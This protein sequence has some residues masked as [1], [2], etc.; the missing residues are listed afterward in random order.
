MGTGKGKTVLELINTFQEVNK[1]KIPY[2]FIDKRKG[3]VQD[4]VA[5]NEL[6][7]SL[8]NWIPE[9]DIFDM[10]RDGWKWKKNNPNGYK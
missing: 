1:I 8:L 4:I 3:D 5:N 6:S 9:R 10:C 2:K 7:K